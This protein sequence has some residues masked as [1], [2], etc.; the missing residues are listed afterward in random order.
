[1]N[2]S[3]SDLEKHVQTKKFQQAF[4]YFLILV[5]NCTYWSKLRH[6]SARYSFIWLI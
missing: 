4:M 3:V 5:F 6:V 2:Q 1:M